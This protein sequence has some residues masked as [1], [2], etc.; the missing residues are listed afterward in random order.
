MPTRQRNV[1][2]GQG[3][4]PP[5]VD[6]QFQL[7]AQ[8]QEKLGQGIAGAIIEHRNRKEKKEKED[9][10]LQFLG[11]Q[12]P[13]LSEDEKKAAVKAMGPEN[14]FLW[15]EQ[16]EKNKIAAFKFQEQQKLEMEKQKLAAEK[17]RY[18]RRQ[19]FL[20]NTTDF[21]KNQ[22]DIDQQI[23]DNQN[24]TIDNQHQAAQLKL[25]EKSA[26]KS[27]L[28][29]GEISARQIPGAPEGVLSIPRGNGAFDVMDTRDEQTA[30]GEALIAGKVYT[31]ETG[32]KV[33]M[34]GNSLKPVPSYS[35]PEQKGIQLSKILE[36]GSPFSEYMKTTRNGDLTL[37][38]AP[39][40]WRPFFMEGAELN[41]AWEET[42][43][44]LGYPA[45]DVETRQLLNP[46]KA[47]GANVGITENNIPSISS[48]EEFDELPSGAE[49]INKKTG[50]RATK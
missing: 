31:L 6:P 37:Q 33:W 9:A 14:V 16:E 43:Q 3:I 20:K 1:F 42:A 4:Q 44:L 45:Y 25:A 41:P 7:Y 22:R 10:A 27:R 30:F 13:G 32:E 17:F 8:G 11:T 47:A 46:K 34:D 24:T 5:Y 50:K 28:T 18:E 19:D 23:F 40:W 2:L 38:E 35:S 36:D 15:A 48:Q 12:M 21:W 26:N 29:Q 49:Y 39:A